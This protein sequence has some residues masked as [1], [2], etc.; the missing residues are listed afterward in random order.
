M[1]G[2]Q[3]YTIF[4]VPSKPSN[5]T[6]ST[7][8]LKK[9]KMPLRFKTCKLVFHVLWK[10]LASIFHNMYTSPG[11]T[12]CSIQ[13]AIIKGCSHNCTHSSG[14]RSRSYSPILYVASILHQ[15]KK[16][17]T[18]SLQKGNSKKGKIIKIG[19]NVLDKSSG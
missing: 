14:S 12:G 3:N 15:A 10:L 19:I 8:F 7:A 16:I 17:T 13:I 5:S 2:G 4:K 1:V 11:L 9:S 18:F 6:I